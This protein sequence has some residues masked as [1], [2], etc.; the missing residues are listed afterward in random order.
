MEIAVGIDQGVAVAA[1][2][3]YS[4]LH[5]RHRVRADILCENDPALQSRKRAAQNGHAV[6]A[7][8]SDR[9]LE[10]SFHRQCRHARKVPCDFAEA[11]QYDVDGHMA[12]AVQ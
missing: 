1:H 10:E 5:E 9:Q 8:I 11:R 12:I 3:E 6:V 7:L 4:R 2:L